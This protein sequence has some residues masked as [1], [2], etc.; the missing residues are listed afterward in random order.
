MFEEEVVGKCVGIETAGELG[1]GG[2]IVGR[3]TGGIAETDVIC[4]ML[5]SVNTVCSCFLL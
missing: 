3:R 4:L 5:Q 2:D 1:R